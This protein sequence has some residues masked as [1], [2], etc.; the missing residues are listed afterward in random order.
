[1]SEFFDFYGFYILLQIITIHELGHAFVGVYRKTFEGFMFTKWGPAVK[2]GNLIKP[3][4][5]LSGILFNIITMP[6]MIG[7]IPWMPSWCYIILVFGMGGLDV[8]IFICLQFKFGEVVGDVI[9]IKI[10]LPWED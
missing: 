5:Y 8:F 2:Y 7:A 3:V 6:I 4:D 10:R 1:M 9:Q